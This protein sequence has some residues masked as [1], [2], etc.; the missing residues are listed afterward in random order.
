MRFIID[1]TDRENSMIKA[2]AA[3]KRKYE[4]G[5]GFTVQKAIAEVISVGLDAISE[6]VILDENNNPVMWNPC[7][8]KD[9]EDSQKR[10]VQRRS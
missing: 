5:K 2:Y 10:S 9:C 6:T 3:A 8:M 7:Y 1:I 4:T